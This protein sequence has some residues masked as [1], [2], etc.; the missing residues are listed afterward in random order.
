MS[1]QLNPLSLLLSE[2]IKLDPSKVETYL[3][4]PA[5]R[6][7]LLKAKSKIHK[8]PYLRNKFYDITTLYHM[9]PSDRV[10]SIKKTGLIP[11]VGEQV[12]NFMGDKKIDP[13]VYTT[14]KK[15]Y[16]SSRYPGISN[17]KIR[18]PNGELK[19]SRV[20]DPIEQGT[21]LG[22]S[23]SNYFTGSALKDYPVT[24]GVNVMGRTADLREILS[25]MS[26]D[27]GRT[28]TPKEFRRMWA[29]ADKKQKLE[30]G[31]YFVRYYRGVFRPNTVAL[32]RSV[33]PEWIVGSGK[34]TKYD[35]EGQLRKDPERTI[36]MINDLMKRS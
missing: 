28:I 22:H 1:Y 20:P 32:K 33:K 8:N 9:T 19:A 27:F 3:K 23:Y 13:L 36:S 35:F 4:D 7:M 12:K 31:K 15:P 30:L 21:K 6:A 18:I 29:K 14:E 2:A 17:I 26:E 10:E 24:R 5:T 11:R 16:M 34:A 25:R